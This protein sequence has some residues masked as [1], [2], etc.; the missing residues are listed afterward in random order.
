MTTLVRF[1]RC[2]DVFYFRLKLL[3][4]PLKSGCLLT[5][6]Q[7]FGV[8]NF[9]FVTTFLVYYDKYRGCRVRNFL[10]I[11]FFDPCDF[12][13][14]GFDRLLGR[15]SFW[16]LCRCVVNMEN[17]SFP[18]QLHTSYRLYAN[19]EKDREKERETKIESCVCMINAC[20]HMGLTDFVIFTNVFVSEN[21]YCLE[22]A[23]VEMIIKI[24]TRVKSTRAAVIEPTDLHFFLYILL[25]PRDLDAVQKNTNRFT[26]TYVKSYA[27]CY[28][29]CR[30]FVL[31]RNL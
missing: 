7:P 16:L 10:T 3:F 29:C 28:V 2:V 20:A 19:T 6:R 13:P 15:V 1:R 22:V 17:P 25:R 14:I 26:L 11:V 8:L 21:N 24:C 18:L 9:F 30:R 27:A 12:F 23:A 31:Y 4:C 5:T